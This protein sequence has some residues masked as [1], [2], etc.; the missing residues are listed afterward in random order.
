MPV[1]PAAILLKNPFAPV[2]E[3]G[4]GPSGGGTTGA[5][6]APFN[7]PMNRLRPF[8]NALPMF[9]FVLV[10]LGEEPSEDGGVV[11]GEG[12]GCMLDVAA[13][14]SVALKPAL[15]GEAVGVGDPTSSLLAPA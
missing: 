6:A 15:I 1:I 12:P 9:R 10:A 2:G 5:T 14:A 7:P 4:A 13:D 11:T 3:L 8:V